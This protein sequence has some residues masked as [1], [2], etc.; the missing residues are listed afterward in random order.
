MKNAVL[1]GGPREAGGHEM[2]YSISWSKKILEIIHLGQHHLLFCI[3]IYFVFSNSR[4]SL[5]FDLLS[6]NTVFRGENLVCY[7]VIVCRFIFPLDNYF[8]EGRN[9]IILII[10]SPALDGT[11]CTINTYLLNEQLR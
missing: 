5:H 11:Q 4:S 6:Q 9:C 7:I 10:V 3:Q 8:L 2:S 1:E